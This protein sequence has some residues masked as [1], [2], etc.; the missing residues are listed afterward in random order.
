M[1]FW[2]NEIEAELQRMKEELKRSS[3]GNA[4]GQSDFN[5]AS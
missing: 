2:D 1:T 5:S 3:G 4:S